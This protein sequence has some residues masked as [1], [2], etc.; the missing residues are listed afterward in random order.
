MLDTRS[1]HRIG[2]NHCKDILDE[3][4]FVRKQVR[5]VVDPVQKTGHGNG[6]PMADVG[7]IIPPIWLPVE[8]CEG[9]LVTVT[10]GGVE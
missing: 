9:A 8:P 10:T 2:F 3:T 4:R 1:V 6:I 7:A 5:T